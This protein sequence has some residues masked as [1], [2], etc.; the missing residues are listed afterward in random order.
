MLHEPLKAML[1]TL[2]DAGANH[3]RTVERQGSTAKLK[4]LA[5][6]CARAISGRYSFS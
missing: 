5:D 1:Q 4:P 3:S 2:S 6:L